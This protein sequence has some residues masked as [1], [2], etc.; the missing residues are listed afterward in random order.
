MVILMI[1]DVLLI[2]CNWSGLH[3]GIFSQRT[4]IDTLAVCRQVV[5]HFKR[6]PLAYDHLKTIQPQ[7]TR[8]WLKQ[9]VSTKWNSTFYYASSN[10]GTKDGFSSLCNR[11]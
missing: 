5:G 2:H 3:D 4:V 7:L 6:S 9:D 10:I 8:H 11:V 1:W